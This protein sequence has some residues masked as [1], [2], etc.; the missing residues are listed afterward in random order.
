MPAV[1][2]GSM[3]V[4]DVEVQTSSHWCENIE[5]TNTSPKIPEM[6]NKPNVN[7]VSKAHLDKKEQAVELQAAKNYCEEL[8]DFNTEGRY[9]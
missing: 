3:H 9:R 5:V 6:S 7:E 4:K 1:Q 2:R 8:Q